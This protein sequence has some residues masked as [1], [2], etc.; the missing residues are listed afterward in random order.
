MLKVLI[1][2]MHAMGEL[3]LCSTVSTGSRVAHG[4]D[5]MGLLYALIVRY[6]FLLVFHCY[7][8]LSLIP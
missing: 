6:G 3:Q 2:L 4:M 7:L 1:Q 8:K 5:A